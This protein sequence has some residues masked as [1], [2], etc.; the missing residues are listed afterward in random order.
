LRYA[1]FPARTESD[2]AWVDWGRRAA[3]WAG[4]GDD[5]DAMI[6]QTFRREGRAHDDQESIAIDIDVLDNGRYELRIEVTDRESGQRAAVHAP[7][8]KESARVADR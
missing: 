6:S 4:F 2:P 8:W 5:E 1:I 7:F 3:E